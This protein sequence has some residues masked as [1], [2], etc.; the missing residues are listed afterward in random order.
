MTM[1]ENRSRLPD[2]GELAKAYEDGKR[3]G[4]GIAAAVMGVVSFLSMLGMEKAAVAIV[5][6]VLATRSAKAK[7]LGL[8]GIALG[9]VFVVTVG[10]VLT[11]YWDK[12]RAVIEALQKLS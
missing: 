2:G 3:V 5:L 4:L 1:Q 11:L 6:G 12:L 8:A 10:V 7:R 9:S